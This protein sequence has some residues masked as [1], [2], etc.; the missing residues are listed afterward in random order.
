MESYKNN[1]SE[2]QADD[3]SQYLE[4]ILRPRTG[5]AW[6]ETGNLITIATPPPTLTPSEDHVEGP[7][8]ERPF[9]EFLWNQPGALAPQ[10]SDDL[11]FQM[12]WEQL[13]PELSVP[14]GVMN[15][16]AH[17]SGES[18]TQSSWDYGGS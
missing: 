10:V 14:E 16:V 4:R 1:I 15:G 7:L 8:V 5:A 17:F 6:E 2:R 13:T 11:G 9:D 3:A 18:F 12:L